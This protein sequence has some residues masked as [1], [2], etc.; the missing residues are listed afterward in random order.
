MKLG[1]FRAIEA[2]AVVV[3]L[4][5]AVAEVDGLLIILIDER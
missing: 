1:E 5:F 4:R 3:P 2:D